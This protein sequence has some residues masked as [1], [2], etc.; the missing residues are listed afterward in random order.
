MTKQKGFTIVEGLFILLILSI[1]GYAGFYVWDNSQDKSTDNANPSKNA[2]ETIDLRFGGDSLIFDLPNGV[3]FTS[4]EGSCNE[5][6]SKTYELNNLRHPDND[7]RLCVVL[8]DP[9]L[10]GESFR[11]NRPY[12]D[13]GAVPIG[14]YI[15]LPPDYL[16]PDERAAQKLVEA[17]LPTVTTHNE[18]VPDDI[19]LA[20]EN[21][22]YSTS[23]PPNFRSA[24]TVYSSDGSLRGVL[25]ELN[26]PGGFPPDTSS[27]YSVDLISETAQGTFRVFGE[28]R[29]FNAERELFAR[30]IRAEAS[31]NDANKTDDEL[32]EI[33][34]RIDDFEGSRDFETEQ[35]E[36]FMSFLRSARNL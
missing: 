29:Y 18:P 12:F 28:L 14:E 21:S 33:S 15:A 5:Y 34:S 16:L 30:Q 36:I 8:S 2:I 9:Y 1:I 4:N 11:D 3:H 13:L 32:G 10:A 24:V 6:D 23:G 27:S 20:I 26:S 35:L 7:T 17:Y 22:L 25:N 19:A 31:A